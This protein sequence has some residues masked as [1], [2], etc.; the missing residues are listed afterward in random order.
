MNKNH[1]S[2]LLL[3][4]AFVLAGCATSVTLSS[5]PDEA[6]LVVAKSSISG[7]LPISTSIGRTTF[8]KYPFKVEKEGCE[9]MYG[10]LPLNVSGTA[11]TMDVL[12]FAP[13]A[14]W[15]AQRAFPFYQF[16]LEKQIIRY[17]KGERDEWKEYPVTEQERSKAMT[18]F[19]E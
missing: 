11:I 15:T 8:G 6:H 1:F 2:A 3:L 12:F 19:G 18:F 10:M 9:P 16:D 5:V 14:F 13:A 17:K 4:A 7:T